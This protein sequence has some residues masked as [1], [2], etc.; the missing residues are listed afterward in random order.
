M[1]Q[2]N[3]VAPDGAAMGTAAPEPQTQA[4]AVDTAEPWRN[5]DEIKNALKGQRELKK[6]FDSLK[7]LIE[8]RL[9][10]KSEAKVES[11][12]DAGVKALER[13]QRLEKDL[14]F[15]E[16][17]DSV[18][19]EA[20]DKRLIRRLFDSERPE[21]VGEWLER[22]VAEVGGR[23]PQQPA[24]Q[25]AAPAPAGPAPAR[26]AEGAL[27][28]DPSRWRKDQLA[29]M[30]REERQRVWNQVLPQSSIAAAFTRKK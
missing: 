3:D 16:A 12:A 20:T 4:T 23:R 30:S 15:R 2:P 6:E 14:A 11:P 17:L 27:P 29:G 8:A 25:A 28:A 5:A 10:P 21:D 13:L 22:T 19:L 26:T 1:S 24:T 9:S 7:Q 18:S